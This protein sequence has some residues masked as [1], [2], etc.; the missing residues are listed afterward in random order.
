MIIKEIT[1][2]SFLSNSKV[3]D[4]TVNPYI[5]CEHCCTYCYARF[6]KRFTRHEEPW[7]KFVDVKVNAVDLLREEIKRKKVG[8]VWISG[9]C[10][11][12]QPLEK[13]YRMTEKC[14]RVLLENDW[15][16][17]IQTKSPLVL[18]DI[19]LFKKFSKAEV[20]LTITTGDEGIKRIFEPLAPSIQARIDALEKLTL[21]G[22]STYAMIGP[23]LPKPEGLVE[24]LA[25]KIEYVLLDKMNYHY[26]DWVYR[27]F[28]LE[29]AMTDKFFNSMK[30]EL[31][32]AFGKIDMPYRFLF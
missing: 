20:G 31:A 15:P 17:R 32:D 24:K 25:G 12:Y 16:I 2:K 30:N 14:L 7:G 10:D 23:I 18:R 5:G 26:A 19:E 9:I 3:F 11:P 29:H 8:R 21:A 13:G 4:Y 22:I 6:M 28:K 1:V 27:Q